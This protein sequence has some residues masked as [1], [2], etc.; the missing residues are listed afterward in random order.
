MVKKVGHHLDMN[1]AK[2]QLMICLGLNK[3]LQ[4]CIY[5]IAI[6]YS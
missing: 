1:E 4:I 3:P 5:K 2:L 6:H